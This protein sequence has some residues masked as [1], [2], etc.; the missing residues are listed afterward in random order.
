MK[1]AEEVSVRSAPGLKHALAS[2]DLPLVR[3]LQLDK[4]P[5]ALPLTTGLQPAEDH[6]HRAYERAKEAVRA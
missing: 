5:R 1:A 3:V 2:C 6:G 4:L